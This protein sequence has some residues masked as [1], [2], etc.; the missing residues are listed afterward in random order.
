MRILEQATSLK[1][2]WW[3]TLIGLVLVPVLVAAGLL[4]AT[5]NAN[6]RLHKVEAAVVNLDKAVTID[7][8]IV[9][10]G[11]QMSAALVDSN[12]EQNFTWVLAD[13]PHAE[14]GL[15]SG[16]YAA[17][18][19]IPA[20]FSAA[21]TSFGGSADS[22]KQATI[23][24]RTSPMAGLADTALGQSVAQAAAEAL[25]RTLTQTYLENVFIGFGEMG[26]Q[27]QTVADAA[28]QLA[29]GNKKLADGLKQAA[30]GSGQLSRGLD[31]MSANTAAVRA[32][33]AQLVSGMD[34][35]S[36]GLVQSAT[37][38]R[39]LSDGLSQLSAGSAGLRG[40]ARSLATGA[41]DISGG[42]YAYR[43]AGLVPY[44]TGVTQLANSTASQLD[45]MIELVKLLEQL[46]QASGTNGD[47]AQY[48]PQVQQAI[49][50]LQQQ[51]ATVQATP[52][53]L[54]QQ[55]AGTQTAINA[56]LDQAA[57]AATVCPPQIQQLGAGACAG[58]LAGAQMAVAQ[59]KAAV[60]QAFTTPNPT[61]GLTLQQ[62]LNQLAA[63]I[64]AMSTSDL[65]ALLN[66][67]NVVLGQLDTMLGQT[68]QA[69][70]P[71]SAQLQAQKGELQKLAAAGPQLV[72]GATSLG[73]GAAKLGGGITAYAD[74]VDKYTG[75][76]DSIAGG[77]KQLADGLGQAAT[78]ASQAASGTRQ[79]VSGVNQ[80]LDGIDQMAPG[81][82]QLADGLDQSASGS[83]QL[84][85]GTRK[86]ADGLAEGATKV[87]SYTKE[88]SAN[89][90]KVVASPISVTELDGLVAPA[91]TW[92]SLL[93][94]LAL[95]CGALATYLVLPALRRRL[96]LSSKPTWRLAAES[97]IPAALVMGVQVLAV[98]AI[99]QVVLGLPVV[100][101]AMLMAFL[102]VAGVTFVGVNHALVAWGKGAGRL[103]A[104]AFAVITVA[105]A[106]TY[107]LPG[108]FDALRGLS[109]LTPA[110]DGVRQ[111]V[112]GGTGATGSVFMLLGWGAVALL[113]SMG[114]V[115]RARTVPAKALVTTWG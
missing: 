47:V 58:Y 40:G 56:S 100:R 2:P 99:A 21:A 65:A 63:S 50:T 82:A 74:G 33:G 19:T 66:Q 27:F 78:G 89:L 72:A 87:P 16:R 83:A 102:A 107:A 88:Q 37:G 34:Q 29:D 96:A 18:V 93:V 28:S 59:G 12:R 97:V 41:S 112:T 20:N 85:D 52:Q 25:N 15:R 38:S 76:V 70:L 64:G 77:T 103:I 113:A 22:A 91:A 73:D 90:A 1:R 80:L 46:Q 95:W 23:D 110:L 48:I 67:T 55:I 51:L 106:A 54:S 60:Q 94:V 3:V 11:R 9:P 30:D 57:Q 109:P 24:V 84:A 98:G 32:G 4:A 105:A 13:A 53:Q 14:A 101:F 7:G 6:S 31:Q 45:M 75:G 111:I 61:T 39:Q 62:S 36:G 10:L 8:Q 5:W 49:K 35:L 92:V 104:I 42:I 69:G 79:Y 86:L 17:V 44:T 108:F 114:A 115:M 71:S 68:G 26:K 43:D 81:A